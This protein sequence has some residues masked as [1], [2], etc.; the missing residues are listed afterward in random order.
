MAHILENSPGNLA[1]TMRGHTSA[2]LAWGA[3]SSSSN[4]P[5]QNFPATQQ[6]PWMTQDPLSSTAQSNWPQ[7]S[8]PA[9]PHPFTPGPAHP[10]YQ[11][12]ESSMPWNPGY[13]PPAQPSLSHSYPGSQPEYDE[14]AAD[15][16]AVSSFGE[17]I[18]YIAPD[19][20]HLAPHQQDEHLYWTC[21]QAKSRW[22][23]HMQKP[24][25]KVRRFF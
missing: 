17:A 8:Y 25:R 15:S 4:Q 7:H 18:D 14:E 22:R 23:R 6:D 11:S 16:D 13:S 1:A 2:F 3:P 21:S 9:T 12:S 19:L 10:Q 5:T 24:V 20:V